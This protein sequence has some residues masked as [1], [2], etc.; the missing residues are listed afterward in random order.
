AFVGAHPLAGSEKRGPD[1]AR[2]DLF[3]GRTTI[4]TPTPHS[5]PS[6]VA[7]TVAFWQALGSRVVLLDAEAH[8]RGLAVTSHLPHLAAAALAGI[9]PAE[10]RD[11]AATGFRDTTR[12]A[13]GDPGLW[14]AIF[15]QNRPALGDALIKLLGRLEEFRRA[16]EA[17]DADALGRL[18]DEGK[19]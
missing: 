13:S 7:R 4:V 6:A 16:L 17:D 10:L 18:L 11:L 2:A 9:L 12:V 3:R 5:D 1:S 14:A 8:D 15:R 19:R